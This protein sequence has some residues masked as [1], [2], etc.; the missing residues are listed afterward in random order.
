MVLTT[1]E[2]MVTD[3]PKAADFLG[4]MFG[5]VVT[6]N[7]VP[8]NEI[9]RILHEGGEEAG[10]IL[11]SGL[12]ADVLGSTLEMIKSI[13]G[14]TGLNEIRKSSNLNVQDFRPPGTIRSRVLEKFI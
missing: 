7:V 4:R 13:K 11:E 3:A 1:L 5:K 12:A 10:Q 6:E 2:D 14:D 9:G 8:L